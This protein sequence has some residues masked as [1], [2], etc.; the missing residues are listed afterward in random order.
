MAA[1]LGTFAI[2][3]MRLTI[4]GEAIFSPDPLE[5]MPSR[6]RGA[7]QCLRSGI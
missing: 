4:I 5:P 7:G 3:F 2:A 1:I 6:L